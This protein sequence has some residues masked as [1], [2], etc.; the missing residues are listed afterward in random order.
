MEARDK[1]KSYLINPSIIGVEGGFQ[2]DDKKFTF[3]EHNSVVVLPDWKIFPLPDPELPEIVSFI[4]V[5]SF[6]FTEIIWKL[7]YVALT[8]YSIYTH[9]IA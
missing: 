7:D 3:E 5:I 9:F 2:T 6:S 8:L 1:K 4:T